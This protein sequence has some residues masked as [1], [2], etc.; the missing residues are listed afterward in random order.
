MQM[1][2]RRYIRFEFTQALYTRAIRAERRDYR[3]IARTRTSEPSTTRAFAHGVHAAAMV[4]PFAREAS[5]KQRTQRQLIPV[6]PIYCGYLQDF[7]LRVQKQSAALAESL[8]RAHRAAR[9]KSMHRDERI[10]SK[11]YAY[12]S[13]SNFSWWIA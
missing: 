1:R 2:E 3:I 9:T 10:K 6:F 7:R 4:R 12:A 13:Q 8:L 11:R 5:P